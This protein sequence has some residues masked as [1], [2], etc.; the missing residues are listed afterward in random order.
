[1]SKTNKSREYTKRVADELGYSKEEVDAVVDFYFS[2]IKTKLNSMEKTHVYVHGLG[3]FR[4]S[5]SK[6][7][8]SIK[9]LE[10]F[11][12]N[13]E[14]VSFTEHA[15]IEQIKDKL[16]KR[17]AFSEKII[18]FIEDGKKFKYDMAKKK[19]NSGGDKEQNI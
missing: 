19:A 4:G 16:E 14:K 13:K 3:T 12:A 9:H 11:L 1:M 7:L 6:C 10:L 2:C 17:K 8:R 5:I 15:R 18:N